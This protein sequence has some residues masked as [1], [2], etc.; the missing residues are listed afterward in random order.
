MQKKT[1]ANQMLLGKFH[2]L[3]ELYRP[4][5]RR[6]DGDNFW[7]ASLDYIVRIGLIKDDSYCEKGT[8]CWVSESDAPPYGC[9]LT[10]W[11]A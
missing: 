6:R 10:V 1:L 2:A 11:D 9:R 5:K 3:L 4:D 7:K 8:F